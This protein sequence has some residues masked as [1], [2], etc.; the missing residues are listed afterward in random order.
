MDLLK[1]IVGIATSLF[2][3]LF[4]LWYI[5]LRAKISENRKYAWI[6]ERRY[7]TAWLIALVGSGILLYLIWRYVLPD[8][9]IEATPLLTSED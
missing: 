3:F 7:D 1:G 9:W 4:P 6:A 8:W 2:L 5:L